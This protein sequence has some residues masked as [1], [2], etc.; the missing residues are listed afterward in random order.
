[1]LEESGIHLS[2]TSNIFYCPCGHEKREIFTTVCKIHP[3]NLVGFP[4]NYFASTSCCWAVADIIC[5]H[6]L[7]LKTAMNFFVLKIC[8]DEKLLPKNL[9]LLPLEKYLMKKIPGDPIFYYC[10]K[11]NIVMEKRKEEKRLCKFGEGEG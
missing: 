5:N 8:V 10:E 7:Y 1:M 3:L 6:C 9:E 11:M 4:R 2:Y